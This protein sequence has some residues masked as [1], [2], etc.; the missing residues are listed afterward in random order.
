MIEQLT[1][2]L[3]NSE[4]HLLS[5]CHALADAGV[6]MSALTI[7]E[8]SEYGLVRIIC[9]DP[10]AGKAAL[11]KA[12]LRSTITKVAAI[13]VPNRP[14]GLVELL[15]TLKRLTLNIEY[16][17]C[18]STTGGRAIDVFR[19]KGIEEAAPQIEAAG[20]RLLDAADLRA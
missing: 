2:F 13:E 18:F 11:D 14:G 5:L 4:G 3:E 8:T 10:A 16:G 1:V 20:F 15:E 6:D 7:A 19:I 9:D 12:G 17:Y